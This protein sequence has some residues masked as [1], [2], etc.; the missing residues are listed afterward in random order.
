MERRLLSVLVA[1]ALLHAG[2]LSNR[3]CTF[4]GYSVGVSLNQEEAA[5]GVNHSDRTIT[6]PPGG[7]LAD[8]VKEALARDGW[9]ITSYRGPEVT[10]YAMFLR[11]NQ[12]DVCVPMF[13]PAYHYHISIVDNESGSEV[14]TLSGR[15]CERRIVDKL[16]EG[17]RVP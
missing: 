6:V 11:W 5:D 13:D 4:E 10:R 2:C 17:L 9:K 14:L 12:F 8:A 3:V 7:G 1:I 15:G 16:V